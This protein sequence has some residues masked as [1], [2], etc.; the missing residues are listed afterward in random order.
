M[1]EELAEELITFIFKLRA[2][3]VEENKL[4]SELQ[5]EYHGSRKEFEY[6]IEI[7]NIGIF[8]ANTLSSGMLYPEAYLGLEENVV[9]KTAF[10]LQ[11]VSL[12]GLD[13]YQTN[14]IER[15]KN[16]ID[17]LIGDFNLPDKI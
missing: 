13:D 7:T 2:S 15:R 12:K 5:K 4:V 6:L 10:R 9:M 11:W 3:G 17:F 8:R 16:F 1:D 14:Y